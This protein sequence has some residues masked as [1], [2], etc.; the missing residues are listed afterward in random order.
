MTPLFWNFGSVVVGVAVSAA[1]V[2]G[3]DDD[4]AGSV[5]GKSVAVAVVRA[6][7]EGVVDGNSDSTVRKAAIAVDN[8]P[9]WLDPWQRAQIVVIAVASF[10][11]AEIQYLCCDAT[12]YL[13]WN[14][15]LH[16]P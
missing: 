11:G 12:P 15:Q 5:D 2:V 7:M 13:N 4:D 16:H 10:E 1:V 9:Q 3:D 6:R 8:V 14:L